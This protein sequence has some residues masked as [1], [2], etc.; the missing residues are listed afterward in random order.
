MKE[1]QLSVGHFKLDAI[2]AALNLPNVG[3]DAAISMTA[4]SSIFVEELLARAANEAAR[5]GSTS[6]KP[7]HLKRAAAYVMLYF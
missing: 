6:V 7:E 5:E 2:K 1:K 3:K 4:A